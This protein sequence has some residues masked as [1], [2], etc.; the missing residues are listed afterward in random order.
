MVQVSICAADPSQY[1]ASKPN[2]GLER[3][4]KFV[5]AVVFAIAKPPGTAASELGQVQANPEFPD[6]SKAVL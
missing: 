4:L 3:A 5:A 1:D 2:A 6:A